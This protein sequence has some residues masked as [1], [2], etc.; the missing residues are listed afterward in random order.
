MV[1]SISTLTPSRAN[2]GRIGT[3]SFGFVSSIVMSLEVMAARPIRLPTSMWSGAIRHS[4]PPSESTPWM[5]RTLDSIPSICAPSETR[6]RQRSWTCGSQAAF[7]ITVSPGVRTA[8]MIVFSVAI[9][10]ASSRKMCSPRR[11]PGA[12]SS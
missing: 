4:P 9:T 12:C 1:P 2:A 5:R 11:P 8:A 3:R 6:K 10:L 7:P